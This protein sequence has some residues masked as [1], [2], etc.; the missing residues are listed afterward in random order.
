[1]TTKEA[2]EVLKKW[3]ACETDNYVECAQ[4]HYCDSC[5]YYI[6]DEDSKQ[7][8]DKAVEVLEAMSWIP[9]VEGC[10]MPEDSTEI[11]VTVYDRACRQHEVKT[12]VYFKDEG[13]IVDYSDEGDYVVMA[14]MPM[15]EV[16]HE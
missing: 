5:P 13:W 12:A 11:L 4:H 7:A 9:I 16:W 8:I 15:P 2:V 1:M 3:I 10:R 14:W 6:T